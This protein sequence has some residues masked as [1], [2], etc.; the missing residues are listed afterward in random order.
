MRRIGGEEGRP[1]DEIIFFHKQYTTTP[2]NSR[3]KLQSKIANNN[4]QKKKS[5]KWVLEQREQ[6]MKRNK[7][8]KEMKS[9]REKEKK[10]EMK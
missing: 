1:R 2:V 7:K 4:Q 9:E 6:A 8:K 5:I 10:G 3:N